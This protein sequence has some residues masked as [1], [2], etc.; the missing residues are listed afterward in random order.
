M[1]NNNLVD[2]VEAHVVPIYSHKFSH[3]CYFNLR[4]SKL[5]PFNE[6]G[7]SHLQYD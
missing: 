5:D 3:I 2:F 6:V 7:K 1:A 4:L